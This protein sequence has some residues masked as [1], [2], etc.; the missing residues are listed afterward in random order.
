MNR[1][2]KLNLVR[3]F[4]DD[5]GSD[6]LS[7]PLQLLLLLCVIGLLVLSIPSLMM[8]SID[9]TCATEAVTIETL[10]NIGC[11]SLELFRNNNIRQ[12]TEIQQQQQQQ[13]GNIGA[14]VGGVHAFHQPPP[15]YDS[16]EDSD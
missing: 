7:P 8:L 3:T 10:R 4:I 14:V 13:Q 6:E 15:L 2:S 11:R 9:F 16:D 5:K 12:P 1:L